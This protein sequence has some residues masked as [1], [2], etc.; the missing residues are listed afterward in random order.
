MQV[1][2]AA[3]A[4]QAFRLDELFNTGEIL[5]KGAAIDRAWLANPVP[6]RSVRLFVGMDLGHR[7]FQFFKC[8]IELDGI[9]LLGLAPEGCVLEGRDQRLKPFDTLILADNLGVFAPASGACTAISIALRAATY[10]VDRRYPAWPEPSKSRNDLALEL[11]VMCHR[12]A[13]TSSFISLEREVNPN[14]T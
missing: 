11:A 1:Q 14:A 10:R 2:P 6:R 9:G 3:G 7:H 5:W 12:A 8:Q 4:N 13:D